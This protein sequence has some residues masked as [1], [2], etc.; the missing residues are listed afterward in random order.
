MKLLTRFKK[1]EYA[2]NS[3]ILMTGTVLSMALKAITALVL[4]YFLGEV[5]LGHFGS[6]SAWNSILL[7]VVT[8]RYELAIML[9]KEDNDGFLLTIL[10]AALSL[11]LSIIMGIVFVVLQFGFHIALGW[12]Q[13]LPPSLAVLGVYYSINYWLNRKK[14]YKKLAINRILQ[15]FFV[16]LFSGLFYAIQFTRDD[17]MIWG[18]IVSQA[19]VLVILIVY[20]VRDYRKYRFRIDLQR[21]KK[22]AIEYINF[23]R[24]SVVAGVVNNITMKLPIILLGFF[25]SPALVGQYTLMDNILAA[26]IALVSEAVRD[27]FRQ[28]ASRDY[29]DDHECYHTYKATF[30][31][32]ALTAILPFVLIMFGAKP[33][34][35]II[36]H[37]QFAMAGYF[38]MIMAPFFYIRFV[39]APLTFMT[40]IAGKQAF[41]MKWQIGF[42]ISS[43]CAFALGFLLTHNPYVMILFYGISNGIMYMISLWYTRK[44]AKGEK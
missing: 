2:K 4:S 12:L 28:K 44:L 32:L 29:A 13:F 30:K 24:L 9:P 27:V 33:I 37:N 14:C 7:V 15:G 34:I 16:A 11:I 8:G 40:Y 35:D 6:F 42:C 38:I 3:V 20:I 41:D 26:P 1:S 21:M 43:T 25:G 10:S 31:T 36:Y 23:P 39:V 19:A 5:T 18:Y 17:S 22:L